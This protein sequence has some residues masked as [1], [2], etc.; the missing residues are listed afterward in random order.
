METCD[1]MM[2]RRGRQMTDALGVILDEVRKRD[3]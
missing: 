3:V 2:K 1:V